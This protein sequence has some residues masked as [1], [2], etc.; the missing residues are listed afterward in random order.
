MFAQ[1]NNWLN[2]PGFGGLILAKFNWLEDIHSK[3]GYQ[4]RDQIIKTLADR[5][6]AELPSIA[7]GVVARIANT[8]FAFLLT[9]AEHHQI[10]TYL[11][12]L[13]IIINQ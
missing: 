1:I 8:E 10:E 2:E 5:M 3:Y 6:Q 13:I 7:Q 9:K 11:S 4:G 12:T